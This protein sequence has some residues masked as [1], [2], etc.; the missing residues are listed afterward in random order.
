MGGEIQKSVNSPARGKKV[1][2]SI[3]I[4]R[5]ANG[6]FIVRHSFDNSMSGPSYMQD[7]MHTFD[8]TAKLIAHVE[9]VFKGA[10]K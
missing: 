6:G 2:E 3:N 7:E 1:I 5:S 4:K 8:T 10:A 9:S